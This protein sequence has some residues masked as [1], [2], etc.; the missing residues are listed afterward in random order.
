MF[1][2]AV[3]T[4]TSVFTRSSVLSRTRSMP[5]H[6]LASANI[7]SIHTFLLRIQPAVEVVRG[8]QLLQRDVAGQRREA[9]DLRAHHGAAASRG[10][11]REAMLPVTRVERRRND[12]VSQY[13]A[14][15]HAMIPKYVFSATP[16]LWRKP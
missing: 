5:C 9:A 1:C 3:V 8:N 2:P 13:A 6:C 16:L 7:G 11:G 4:R 14:R 15:F 12:R 10:E